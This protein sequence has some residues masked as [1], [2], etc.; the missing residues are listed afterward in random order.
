MSNLKQMRTL[1]GITQKKLAELVGV[2][3][4]TLAVLERKGVYD[5]RTAVKYARALNCNPIFLL[6]GLG[7]S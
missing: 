1:K 6:D 7:N 2:A 5:T 3:P 4:P